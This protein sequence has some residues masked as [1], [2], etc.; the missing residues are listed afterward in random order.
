MKDGGFDNSYNDYLLGIHPPTCDFFDDYPGNMEWND[1]STS[2]D[3]E[4]M[5][6][7]PKSPKL[8]RGSGKRGRPPSRFRLQMRQIHGGE[9]GNE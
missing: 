1:R 5:Q 6:F 4:V 3:D 7:L 9:I 8:G 2:D